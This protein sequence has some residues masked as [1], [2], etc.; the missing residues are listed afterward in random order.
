M[1]IQIIFYDE[2]Q[3]IRATDIDR[4]R[5]KEICRPHLFAYYTLLSQMRCKGGNGYYE[6]VKAILEKENLTIRDYKK[7]SNYQVL[8]MKM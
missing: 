7:I 2:L 8:L 5:F 4:T 6:Y 3:T 1:R